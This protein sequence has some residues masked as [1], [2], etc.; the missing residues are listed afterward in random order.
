LIKWDQGETQLM[1]AKNK[2]MIKGQP[3]HKISS[4]AQN[5]PE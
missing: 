4:T 5:T 1:A 2:T 3:E